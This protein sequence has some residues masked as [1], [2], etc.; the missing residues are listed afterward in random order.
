MQNYNEIDINSP[1]ISYINELKN[2]NSTLENELCELLA[3][4]NEAE[5]LRLELE[6]K[7]EE[8]KLLKN[9]IE[10]IKAKL[11]KIKNFFPIKIFLAI[12][13]KILEFKS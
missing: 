7:E 12:K 1:I 3:L 5:A 13:R 6:R 8:I 2:T 9:E 4:K 10:G 11:E